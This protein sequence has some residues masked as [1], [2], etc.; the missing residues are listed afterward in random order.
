MIGALIGNYLKKTQAGDLFGA[1][2]GAAV[3]TILGYWLLF[4]TWL[5]YFGSGGIGD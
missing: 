3:G 1:L 4:S 2:F 5:K